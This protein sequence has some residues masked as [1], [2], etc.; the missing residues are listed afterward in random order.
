MQKFDFKKFLIFGEMRKTIINEG[1]PHK[2]KIDIKKREKH[3]KLWVY[4]CGSG[5]YFPTFFSHSKKRVSFPTQNLDQKKKV[6]LLPLFFRKR[7]V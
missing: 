1:T 3:I 2:P 7:I 6:F 5:V 4:H